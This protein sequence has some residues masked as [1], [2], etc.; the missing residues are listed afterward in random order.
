MSELS[1]KKD[2]LLNR[3]KILEE[4]NNFSDFIKKKILKLKLDIPTASS[5][6][7]D[8]IE[9]S[10][11]I[12]EELLQELNEIY[13]KENLL[14]KLYK[15]ILNIKLDKR[16]LTEKE[17]TLKASIIESITTKINQEFNEDSP[18][19]GNLVP[20][21]VKIKKII[22]GRLLSESNA[23][24]DTGIK[25]KIKHKIKSYASSFALKTLSKQKS[26]NYTTNV[27]DVVDRIII[28][29]R[30]QVEQLK[31]LLP[32][33][34]YIIKFISSGNYNL[35]QTINK[36][37]QVIIIF[38]V[39]NVADIVKEKL[40]L[41]SEQ[42][43]NLVDSVYNILY[44]KF[45]NEGFIVKHK[46]KTNDDAKLDHVIN[47]KFQTHE[48]TEADTS[49]IIVIL[50]LNKAKSIPNIFSRIEIFNML[51]LLL[52][53]FKDID[54]PESHDV[55]GG[56]PPYLNDESIQGSKQSIDDFINKFA[57]ITNIS[58]GDKDKVF[59]KLIDT[60]ILK[61]PPVLISSDIKIKIK[62]QF[63]TNLMNQ[64]SYGDKIDQLVDKKLTIKETVIKLFS[65]Y[66][67]NN[68]YLINSLLKS[69]KSSEPSDS[70]E[71]EPS[72]SSEKRLVNDIKKILFK[73][74]DTHLLKDS[75][76]T[77][78]DIFSIDSDKFPDDLKLILSSLIDSLQKLNEPRSY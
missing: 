30:N 51:N 44:S 13:E 65:E 24:S 2:E 48:E 49:E 28:L 69:I 60:C 29:I 7:I 55:S 53:K 22:K 32:E 43:N 64:L 8:S 57:S 66:L 14:K 4:S 76:E 3:I 31:E 70:S 33:I 34:L 47:I 17:A 41:D 63:L 71:S 18:N 36:S 77:Y 74:L 68:D 42:L 25:Y 61:D 62:R 15:A 67:V 5:T 20:L 75:N 38:Y 16:K 59:I 45:S 27:E 54:L 21:I 39:L 37:I 19:K 52:N 11:K 58:Y 6:T 10:L 26:E 9:K 78:I 46:L 35:E 40:V 1:E 50:A 23:E 72:D 56:G 73:K 12:Y